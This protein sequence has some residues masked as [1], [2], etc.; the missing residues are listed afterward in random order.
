MRALARQL[1]IENRDVPGIRVRYVAPGGVDTPIYDQAANYAGFA[2]RPP[3]PAAS[4]ARTARQILRRVE[5]VRA[6]EQLSLLNHGLVAAYQGLPRLYDAL[7]GAVFP[8]GATDL[9][10]PVPAGPGNVLRPRPEAEGE[11]GH[12]GS[13]LLGLLGNLLTRRPRLAHGERVWDGPDG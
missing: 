11:D 10:R 4:A 8:V 6:P 1:R 12:H 2:G 5:G 7:I 13:S 3:P 9:R